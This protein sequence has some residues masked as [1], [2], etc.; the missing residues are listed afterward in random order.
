MVLAGE[1]SGPQFRYLSDG[2]NDSCLALCPFIQLEK[3]CGT[4]W[5]A[6]GAVGMLG[7]TCWH[8]RGTSVGGKVISGEEEE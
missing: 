1:L 8:P 7:H 3:G 5:R 4:A 2:M 6:H